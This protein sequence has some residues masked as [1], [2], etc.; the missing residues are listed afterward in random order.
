MVES[1]VSSRQVRVLSREVRVSSCIS[2]D[3][4]AAHC[5]TYISAFIHDSNKISTAIPMYSGSSNTERLVG[6]LSDVRVCRKSR[7]AA[8]NWK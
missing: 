1:R 3:L 6:I 7:M 2:N 4:K 8:I 5:S